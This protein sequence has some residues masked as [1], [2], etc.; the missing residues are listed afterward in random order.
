MFVVVDWHK[1]KLYGPFETKE[2]AEDW[3]AE[4]GILDGQYEDQEVSICALRPQTEKLE[5][6]P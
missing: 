2:A 5:D 4:Q 3:L 6:I 1:T